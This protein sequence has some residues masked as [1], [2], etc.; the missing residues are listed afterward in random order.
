M[1]NLYLVALLVILIAGVG[2]L[3]WL[4]IRQ[5]RG[6]GGDAREKALVNSLET[7][8]RSIDKS[9]QAV[10][11]EFALNRREAAE[12]ARHQR[13]EAAASL[14]RFNDS[15][16]TQMN[17]MAELQDKRFESFGRQIGV[18]VES[19]DKKSDALRT[20]VEKKLESLQQ[21]NSKKL[22]EMRKTV[23]EKLQGTL[24]KRLAESFKLV[25]QRLEMVHKGLGEMKELANGV[26][27]L[28]RVMT[29]VK[30]R[31]VWGEYQL[32]NL[33]EQF[34]TPDQYEQNVET[35]PNSNARVEY[36]IKMPGG[37]DGETLFMPIDAKFP[38][39]DY[40]RLVDAAQS[41]DPDAVEQ[42]SKQLDNAIRKSAKDICEKYIGPPHTTN[43]A[44]MYLPTEGLYAEIARRPGMIEQL[45]RDH[46]VTLAG[47]T[48]L[49][50]MLNALQM[51]FRT[52]AIEKRSGEVWKL[53]GQV[54]DEFGK[55]SETIAK[56]K[57][58]LEEASNTVAKVE[59][60]TRMMGR[61]LKGV[62]TLPVDATP[63]LLALSREQVEEQKV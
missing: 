8:A 58:K 35:R 50:A 20:A 38:Q 56:V 42:A 24:E 44:I 39:E 53:L 49:V 22:D 11:E 12:A 36:A 23:D 47:P 54:R 14:K 45:Q 1:P 46:R 48:N 62:D 2:V 16:L 15:V 13:E 4:L 26:G 10:R 37:E 3:I 28:K 60:R 27:D 40:Q 25:S 6:Q 59:T 63:P 61:K 29:N 17:K 9:H 55:F 52:L 19:N 51:G 7:L 30:T 57:K 21:D 18:L 41:A 31:G 5:Q 32:G 34:L 43:F 33:L